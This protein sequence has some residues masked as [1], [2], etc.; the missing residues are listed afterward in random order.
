DEG[1]PAS[2]AVADATAQFISMFEKA[3]GLMAERVTDLKDVRDRVT[4]CI[5][6]V[7]EPG[8]P[9][10][11]QPSVLVAQD[12]APADTAGLDPASIIGLVT[13]RGGPTSHTAIIAR[14]LGIPCAVAVP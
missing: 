3:G 10:P 1:N 6:G 13:D 14:Q 11:A 4:A 12:L 2:C 8:V 5:L 9:A 7:P